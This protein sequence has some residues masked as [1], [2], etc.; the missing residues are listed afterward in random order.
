M[1]DNTISREW[2]GAQEAAD[3]LGCS[4]GTITRAAARKR[5]GIPAFRCGRRLRFRKLEL[6]EWLEKSRE[7]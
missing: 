5:L 3:Y 7:N 4:R 1:I 6:D 2:I